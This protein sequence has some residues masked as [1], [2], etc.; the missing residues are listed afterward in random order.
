MP[1]SCFIIYISEETLIY[2]YA[3]YSQL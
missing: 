2:A 1:L 3:I